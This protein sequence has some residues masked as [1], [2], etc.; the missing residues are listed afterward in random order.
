MSKPTVVIIAGGENSRFFPLNFNTYK[1]AITLFGQPLIVRALAS[2]K[3]HGYQKVVIVVSPKNYEGHGL[4]GIVDQAQLGLDVSYVLQPEAKGMGDAVL[5]AREQLPESFLVTSGYQMNLGEL[6][7]Q[8]LALPTTNVVCATHTTQP[9]EYGILSLK[10]ELASGIIEKPERGQEPSNLK[11]QTLYKLDQDFMQ[12]LRELPE[13]PYNFE[14]AL[15]LLMK[16]QDVGVLQLEES[17]PTLKYVWHLFE[18][19]TAFFATA[20]SSTAAS[21]TIAKTAVI[22]DSQGP[23]IIGDDVEIGHAARIVG[24]CYLGDGVKVGDFS[25]VRSSSL[26][27]GTRVGAH[28]EIARSIILSHSSVHDSYVADS[29]IGSHVRI[30]AGLIT[31]NKRLDRKSVTATVKGR[32]IDSNRE[33]LGVLIGDGANLGIRVSTMPGVCIGTE[34]TVFP[35]VIVYRN[36]D[37]QQKLFE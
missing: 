20:R 19:Q 21:A 2:L 5:Q 24:P 11:V 18:F 34:A 13:S 12:I 27:T 31:A 36:L 33:A 32:K 28:T 26:E 23:V 7:D 9:W 6:A 4:S 35:G 8:L 16:Q 1:G 15:D 17:L 30:G 22:D 14:K 29:I 25:L 37:H 3:E 10:G